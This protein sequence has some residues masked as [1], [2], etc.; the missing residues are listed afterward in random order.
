[1]YKLT[2]ISTVNIYIYIYLTQDI[3]LHTFKLCFKKGIY[4]KSV[5]YENLFFRKLNA[6]YSIMRI[7]VLIELP[8]ISTS[9]LLLCFSSAEVIH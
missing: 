3:I 2:Y 1:M 6:Y 4:S 5:L 8:I 9:I 7:I